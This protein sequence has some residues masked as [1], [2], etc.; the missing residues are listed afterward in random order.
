MRQMTSWLELYHSHVWP[1]VSALAPDWRP[2]IHNKDRQKPIQYFSGYLR[3]QNINVFLA[4]LI[5]YFRV[6]VLSGVRP[7]PGVTES[8]LLSLMRLMT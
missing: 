1:R 5:T 7:H 6:G 4:I 3:R 8:P 2:K